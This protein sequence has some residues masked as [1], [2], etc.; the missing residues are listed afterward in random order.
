MGNELRSIYND[1]Y[2]QISEIPF[3]EDLTLTYR[4]KSS[5]VSISVGGGDIS[6]RSRLRKSLQFWRVLD[7][8]RF[9]L[10]T[11]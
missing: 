9:F 7:E 6:A 2:S 4:F 8:S 5:H 3:P 1:K 11:I 10:D